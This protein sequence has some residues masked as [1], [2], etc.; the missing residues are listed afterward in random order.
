MEDNNIINIKLKNGHMTI[1]LDKFFPTSAKNLRILLEAVDEDVEHRDE[2]RA[3]IVRHCGHRASYLMDGRKEWANKAV[4]HHT[5]A[6]ELQPKI[7]QLQSQVKH[8]QEYIKTYCTR[9][10]GQ[11]YRKQ[12]KELKEQLKEL[13]EEQRH[14]MAVYRNYQ[15]RFVTAEN[16]AKK[17]EK[18][19]EAVDL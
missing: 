2:L 5:K 11:G 10:G 13:K 15:Q 17:L 9:N 7:D 4:D 1:V 6:S 3:A 12:L 14:E 18:N 16:E 19:K 8:L